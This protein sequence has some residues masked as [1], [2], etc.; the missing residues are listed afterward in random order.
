MTGTMRFRW[1]GRSF[2][3]RIASAVDLRGVLRLDEAHWVATT[4]PIDSVLC[5]EVFLRSFDVENVGRIRCRQV[6]A[7]IQW[8]LDTLADHAGV[9]ARSDRLSVSAVNA[10]AP[11]GERIR[12]SL[13]KMLDRLQRGP[14]GE[15]SL[16]EI[17][18][19]KREAEARPVS[20]EGVVL[21][22]AAD[23]ADLRDYL[24][25][26]VAVTGGRAHPAGG[27]GVGRQEILR[28]NAE[29][30]G[31]IEWFRRGAVTE[32]GEP[33]VVQPLGAATAEA[34]DA[35]S[36]IRAKLDQ[37][38][39]Q[40]EAVSLDEAL[41]G[42][43]GW[44]EEELKTLDFDD[45]GVI[46]KVL[47]E[48][49]LARA[50]ADRLLHFDEPCNPYYLDAVDRFRRRVVEPVLG[51]SADA[52]AAADWSR[53]KTTFAAHQQWVEATPA[54]AIRA[55]GPDKLN[56]YLDPS[57][58]TR[59]ATLA[60]AAVETALVLDNIRLTEKL[61]LHQRYTIDLANNFVS[62]PHLYDPNGRAMFEMGTLI[63]DGRRFTLAVGAS[64]VAAH[65]AVAETS[66]M[67][68]MYVEIT[69][70]GASAVTAAVP[71]TSGGRG[72]LCVGKRGIFQDVQGRECD[73]RVVRILENPVSLR[74][75]VL[76][77]FL[78]LGT[79]LT[80]KIEALTSESQKKF[81]AQAGAAMDSVVAHPQA[82]APQPVQPRPTG[83]TPGNLILGAGVAVAAL[84]SSLAYILKTI[85]SA[86][87]LALLLAVLAA[88]AVVVVPT[89][90]VAWIK[91]RRRDLSAILEGAGWGINARMRLTWRQQRAFSRRPSRP[92]GSR[93]L[94]G[95]RVLR[96]VVVLAVL[97]A[98]AG[99]G[100]W[101][102]R[103]VSNRDATVP[104][105]AE[106][107]IESPQTQPVVTEP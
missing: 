24:A 27:S 47:R 20:E 76:A 49:P 14:Q 19:F 89:A 78:R 69:R 30:E 80:G 42:R 101:I 11:D 18:I 61:A 5:D 39:A 107:N 43:M 73:A 71:V 55:I 23:E 35:L 15:V 88:A 33:T 97:A 65:A 74:E 34:F 58:A 29:A 104:P 83:A 25:Q 84:G 1:V 59:V 98:L 92:R 91:L 9:D 95:R 32:G 79:L 13:G 103:V 90:I 12:Q 82:A 22:D 46:E 50:N 63:M 66:R 37:F 52:L 93:G 87:P 72:N 96:A 106:Q 38:F 41:V 85:A 26:V 48:A 21:P 4:A 102:Y 77:P 81:D 57:Y 3:L 28:F 31:A 54:E 7:A 10:D 99:G 36:A 60:E 67:F 6:R 40:C 17:R 100:Y 56:V 94:I 64:D 51:G 44:T 70:P 2:H 45:P 62:F 86:N 8:L 68:L 53:I 105:A 75:A 16:A